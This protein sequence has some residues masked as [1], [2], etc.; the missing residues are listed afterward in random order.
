[1]NWLRRGREEK[2]SGNEL[3]PPASVTA[4]GDLVN[5]D[6]DWRLAETAYGSAHTIPALL[7]CLA[8]DDHAA[9]MAA[10]HDLWC[11]LCHQ[12]AYVSSAALPALPALL[13]ALDRANEELAVEIL[14]ILSGF[15]VCTSLI[16][17]NEAWMNTPRTRLQEQRSRFLVLSESKNE[18]I[19]EMA[20]G[21]AD[22]LRFPPV[23][24]DDFLKLT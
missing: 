1:M 8:G 6:I 10:S 15:A 21:I 14:D 20:S 4:S 2:S 13:S 23:P 12:H 7:A 16:A 3:D 18:L 17:R 11:S 9:A 5:S 24:P 22:N 19:A